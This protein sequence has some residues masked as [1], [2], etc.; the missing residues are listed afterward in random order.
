MP[1][2]KPTNHLFKKNSTIT[3]AHDNRLSISALRLP[4]PCNNIWTRMATIAI[5][6]SIDSPGNSHIFTLNSESGVRRR[7]TICEMTISR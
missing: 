7:N 5:A 6:V 2:E 4:P 1:G 3:T